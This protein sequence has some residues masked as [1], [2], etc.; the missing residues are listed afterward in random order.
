MY[1]YFLTYFPRIIYFENS[2]ID[3]DFLNKIAFITT[4]NNKLKLKHSF[5]YL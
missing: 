3:K 1:F 2:S 5:K 4:I